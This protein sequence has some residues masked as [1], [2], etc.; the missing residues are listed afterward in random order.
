MD[1]V[2]DANVIFA[3]LVK[4]GFTIELLLE[5]ELHLFAPE[6]LFTEISKYKKD[7]IKKTSRSE[8]EFDEIF[9]ILRQRITIIPKEEFESFL[10]EA[11]SICPDENDAVYFALALKLN[12]SIWSNDKKL[13]EQNIIKIYS[14]KDLS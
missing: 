8:E 1:L 7:L 5:P 9:E 11:H 4:D 12:I 3:A 2:V 6:F 10:K 13:K 14:T